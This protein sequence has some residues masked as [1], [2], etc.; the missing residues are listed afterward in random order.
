MERIF[1]NANYRTRLSWEMQDVIVQAKKHETRIGAGGRLP[2]FCS[3]F[4]LS[5][6]APAREPCSL[7]PRIQILL[8]YSLAH[9]RLDLDPVFEK[10][11]SGHHLGCTRTHACKKDMRYFQQEYSWLSLT[12]LVVVRI[13]LWKELESDVAQSRDPDSCSLARNDLLISLGSRFCTPHAK[14]AYS[15]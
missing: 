8:R 4:R 11:D 2:L 12:D 1:F 5:L 15:R 14:G 3:R 6:C 10:N 13:A 9:W 7:V